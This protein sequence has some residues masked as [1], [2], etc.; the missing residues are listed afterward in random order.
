M[1]Q[2]IIKS[3]ISQFQLDALLQLL[4]AWDVDAEIKAPAKRTKKTRTESVEKEDFFAETR[5]MW[6]DYDIDAK[7]LR[8]RASGIDKRLGLTAK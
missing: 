7:E 5:G 6:A 3:P 1:A 2:I 8:R 4:K